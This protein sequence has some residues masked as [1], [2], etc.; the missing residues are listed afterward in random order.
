MAKCPRCGK[1][2]DHLNYYEVAKVLYKAEYYG[3][4]NY[5]D[6]REAGVMLVHYIMATRHTPTGARSRGLLR[7][8]H[9]TAQNA[10]K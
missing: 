7:A 1:E 2:I 10:A 3:D 9:I 4:D 6:F 8:G 5:V